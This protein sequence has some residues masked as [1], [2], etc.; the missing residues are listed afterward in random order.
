VYVVFFLFSFS[1]FS[2]WNEIAV[3]IVLMLLTLINPESHQVFKEHIRPL[4]NIEFE[5][6][7]TT[8]PIHATELTKK[9]F[10]KYSLWAKDIM[11]LGGN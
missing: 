10:I 2:F 9:H 4:L 3:R 7:K 8:K 6:Y 11:I 5:A 1:L